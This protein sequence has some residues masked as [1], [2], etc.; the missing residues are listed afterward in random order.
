METETIGKDDIKKKVKAKI[1]DELKLKTN[2]DTKDK[3]DLKI[4]CKKN[5]LKSLIDH[6]ININ[7]EICLSL[8]KQGFNTKQVDVTHVAMVDMTIKRKA[9]DEY[10]INHDCQIGM[11]LT[12]L[13]K[14]L[15]AHHTDIMIRN[16]TNQLIFNGES[17][18]ENKMGLLP[19][20]DAE[21]KIPNIAYSVEAKTKAEN[22]QKMIEIASDFGVDYLRF[23]IQ[24]NKLII[25]IDADTDQVRFPIC[26]INRLD[27]SKDDFQSLYSVDYLKIVTNFNNNDTIYVKFGK[28]T[29]ISIEFDDNEEKI[30]Y[31][32]APRIETEE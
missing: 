8:T 10:H 27:D 17:G 26:A 29:A 21:L 22:I 24:D 15:K 11:N 32:L 23:I 6:V 2:D 5:V 31:F 16:G 7:D 18:L 9:F 12:T 14:H 4:E 28:D 25:H 30:T 19:I 13:S 1:K 20:I 3:L